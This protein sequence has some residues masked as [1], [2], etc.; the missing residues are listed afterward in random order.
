M[1]KTRI[2]KRPNPPL[3]IINIQYSL[4]YVWRTVILENIKLFEKQKN[5]VLK[6][7]TFIVSSAVKYNLNIN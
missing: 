7:L 1:V 2:S 4:L 3:T 5:S 6:Q